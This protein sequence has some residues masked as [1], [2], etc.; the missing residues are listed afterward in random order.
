M[1][2]SQ[3]D[4]ET[5]KGFESGVNGPGRR[6]GSILYNPTENLWNIKAPKLAFVFGRLCFLTAP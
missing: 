1:T 5:Y 6:S 3:V 2:A 4:R